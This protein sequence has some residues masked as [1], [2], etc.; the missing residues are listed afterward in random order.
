MQAT[1]QTIADVMKEVLETM[2]FALVLPQEE[3]A[4]DESGVVSAR[5]AFQGP[6]SGSI[7]LTMP[8]SI[9]PELAAN[10]LGTDETVAPSEQQQR[11]AVGE[12]ANVM[13][14]N[15]V[16]VVAGPEPVFRLH[17]PVVATAS[18]AAEADE[19]GGFLLSS[20][21]SLEKGWAEL[22]LF[23]EGGRP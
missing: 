2:A 6:F 1:E 20:R 11:D 8:G 18:D 3:E 7:L 22:S 12:L 21:V 4:V 17:A 23:V 14:G 19:P 15:L 5:V 13:C 9:V 10:M 16:Q